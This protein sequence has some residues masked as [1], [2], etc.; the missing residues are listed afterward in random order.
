MDLFGYH[1]PAQLLGGIAAGVGIMALTGL[2]W[3]A[4]MIN[5]EKASKARHLA[6]TQ[7][8]VYEKEVAAREAR[9]ARRSI[10]KQAA[11]DHA[12]TG[13]AEQA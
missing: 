3:L 1:I 7:S 2:F 4:E 10:P 6:Y 9:R 5:E 8:G 12:A 11:T 13:V